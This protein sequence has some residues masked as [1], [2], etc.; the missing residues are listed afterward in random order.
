MSTKDMSKC[1]MLVQERKVRC[2]LEKIPKSY[3]DVHFEAGYA[4][5][6]GINAISFE[7]LQ[8]ETLTFKGKT[9][10]IYLNFHP[11]KDDA[12]NMIWGQLCLF[13]SSVSSK[14]MIT[15][16]ESSTQPI[17]LQNS[18]FETRPTNVTINTTSQFVLLNNKINV[19]PG[20]AFNGTVWYVTAGGN[21]SLPGNGHGVQLGP[22][23]MINQTFKSDGSYDYVLTFT[24]APSSIECANN[25]TAVNVSGPSSSKVFNFKESLEIEMWQTYAYSI[26]SAEIRHGV[27]GIQIQSVASSSACWPI[28]D[29]ILVNGIETLR[30]YEAMGFVNSGFEV[31]PTFI[32]NSSQGILLEPGSDEDPFNPYQS[33]QS[34]LQEW[35]ILGMVKYI[36]SKHY[37]VPRGR[38]AIELVSGS[39]SGIVYNT[40]FLKQGKVIIDFFMG[41][42][43]DSCVGDFMVFLQ[44]K[45]MIWNFTMRSIGIGSSEKHSVTFNA[46]FSNNEWIPISF[47]SFNE[48]RTSNHQVLCGPMIDSPTIQFSSGL[49]SKKLH[50]IWLVFSLVFVAVFIIF[51]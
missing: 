46:K 33:A 12:V 50:H 38:A 7:L 1:Q 28:V 40:Q 11:K 3:E 27:M 39:P 43:N 23:G 14:R 6:E 48:T 47:Y 4:T 37:A 51:I 9:I 13:A 34:P 32:D 24:L 42:A 16:H 41:D 31:G 17:P 18:G 22:N 29:T 19:I 35:T 21:I 8:H 10:L 30:M 49:R 5:G 15:N 25:F 26:W 36:D 45:N 2:K 20:W 44:V